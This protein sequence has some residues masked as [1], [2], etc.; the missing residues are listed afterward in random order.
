MS[1]SN[2]T[3]T[4]NM[5]R[6]EL[7]CST[8]LKGYIALI[9]SGD[10]I[11]CELPGKSVFSPKQYYDLDDLKGTNII[12][13]FI[14]KDF[15]H[16]TNLWNARKSYVATAEGCGEDNGHITHYLLD[17]MIIREICSWY[18]PMTIYSKEQLT[19]LSGTMEMKT[20]SLN[21][22]EVIETGEYIYTINNVVYSEYFPLEWALT[23]CVLDGF[24]CGPGTSPA[25]C[26]N[27]NYHQSVRGVFIGYCGN[28]VAEY[29]RERSCGYTHYGF[30][31][32]ELFSKD[33]ILD[34][35]GEPHNTKSRGYDSNAECCLSGGPVPTGPDI[36]DNQDDMDPFFETE[37]DYV[38]RQ[39]SYKIL[40][41][42]RHPRRAYG[43]P[44][45]LH[46]ETLHVRQT[47]EM[48][49]DFIRYKLEEFFIA[50]N[51]G[52]CDNNY[53]FPIGPRADWDHYRIEKRPTSWFC[54]TA[55]LYSDDGAE[56]AVAIH[57]RMY[58]SHV[59]TET[60]PAEIWLE[61]NNFHGRNHRYWSMIKAMQNWILGEQDTPEVSF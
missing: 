12:H 2:F 41:S 22:Y 50:N 39:K 13:R 1:D 7:L 53:S 44:S 26:T 36:C 27:C 8:R 19:E 20:I 4:N 45:I 49:P 15:T 30:R 3:I 57:I 23:P 24:I 42:K 48:T 5:V 35:Y 47:D 18:T 6:P 40:P 56:E 14:N 58:V 55:V 59:H 31:Y 11:F 28:C 43:R 61:C 60:N 9:Y 34:Y 46:R 33:P 54:W 51:I 29:P 10:R 38:E 21:L 17:D 25:H 16:A 52:M 37:V 32:P